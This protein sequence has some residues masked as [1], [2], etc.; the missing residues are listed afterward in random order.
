M[1]IAELVQFIFPFLAPGRTEY[2]PGMASV[3][4]LAFAAW[5]GIW[6]LSHTDEQYRLS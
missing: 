1:G 6:R 2:F 3:L 4:L 5:A